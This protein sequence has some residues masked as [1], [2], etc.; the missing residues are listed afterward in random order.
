[1]GSGLTNR[2]K[3]GGGLMH[4]RAV[5]KMASIHGS[6]IGRAAEH[7]HLRAWSFQQR[8]LGN[9]LP[10]RTTNPALAPGTHRDLPLPLPSMHIF[11]LKMGRGALPTP[12]VTPSYTYNEYTYST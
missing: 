4:S 7:N 9:L 3:G 12:L 6:A 5:S 10:V 1:M 11:I 2:V 8:Y